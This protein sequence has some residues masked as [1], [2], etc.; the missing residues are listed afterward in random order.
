[1]VTNPSSV[2]LSV[3]LLCKHCHW[4]FSLGVQILK[5]VRGEV[6]CFVEV[7]VSVEPYHLRLSDIKCKWLCMFRTKYI[8]FAIETGRSENI[9]RDNQVCKLCFNGIGDEFRYLFL[10]KHKKIE[11]FRSKCV[12][13]FSSKHPSMIKIKGLLSCHVNLL[14][15]I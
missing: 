2:Y 4:H 11:L 5:T 10:C 13:L 8:K 6:L 7:G 15:N 14:S 9:H 3:E 1:M 12:L